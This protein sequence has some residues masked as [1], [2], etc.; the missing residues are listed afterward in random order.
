MVVHI[1]MYIYIYTHTYIYI[2]REREINISV[3]LLIVINSVRCG[4]EDAAELERSRKMSF[5]QLSFF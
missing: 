5:I 4:N 3:Y 1:H 2:E